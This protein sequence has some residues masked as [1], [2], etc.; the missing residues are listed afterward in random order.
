ME[1]GA[2]EAAKVTLK[3]ILSGIGKAIGGGLKAAAKAVANAD[4]ITLCKY[5]IIIG[6][7]AVTIRY[8]CKYLRNRRKMYMNEE[9]KSVVDRALELNYAD[10]RNQQE[11]HP[12]MRRVR[13]NLKRGM[14]RG[15]KEKYRNKFRKGKK[16]YQGYLDRASRKRLRDELPGMLSSMKNFMEDEE[17]DQRYHG[18]D[19]ASYW[20]YGT[21]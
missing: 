19:L 20:R 13:K 6:I 17:L 11:L 5:G 12:L 8:I 2:T 9:N 21:T 15:E 7:S 14:D 18:C 4:L 16:K 3:T 10:A 1:T